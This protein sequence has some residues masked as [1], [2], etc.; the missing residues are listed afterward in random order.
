MTDDNRDEVADAIRARQSL[1]GDA[2]PGDADVNA[3]NISS[4]L[5]F[6]TS[7]EPATD[8]EAALD[9]DD[10]DVAPDEGDR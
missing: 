3:Q 1:A 4:G 5:R 10:V 9:D 6:G 2:H 8:D 7:D